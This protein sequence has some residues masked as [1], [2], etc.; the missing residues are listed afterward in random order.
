MK[1]LLTIEHLLTAVFV[2]ETICVTYALLFPA[3]IPAA[4]ILYFVCGSMIAALILFLPQAKQSFSLKENAHHLST[5][6]FRIVAIIMMGV[7]LFHFC[8]TLIRLTFSFNK[9]CIT[10]M[11]IISMYANYTDSF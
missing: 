1:K 2:A 10:Y 8:K 6:S 11:S 4:S 9:I 5:L 7:E 3:L